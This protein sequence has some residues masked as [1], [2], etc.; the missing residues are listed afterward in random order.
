MIEKRIPYT[1]TDAKTIERLVADSHVHLNHMVL[2]QGDRLPLH[3]SNANLYMIILRGSM[4][5]ALEEKPAVNHDAG[6][7]LNIPEGVMM[8]VTN[9]HPDVL[10]FFVIKAPAPK[11]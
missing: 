9:I 5:I 2:P 8:D 10:E 6:S 1:L 3:R 7:I 11:I 4:T